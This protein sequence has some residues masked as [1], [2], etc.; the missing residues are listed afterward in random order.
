M[1]GKWGR[2]VLAGAGLLVLV[3]VLLAL[4]GG[5][6]DVEAG[7]VVRGDLSV[8]VDEEGR[9]RLR[10]RYVVTSPV[11]GRVARIA[12]REGDS[13]AAGSLLTRV[14]PPPLDERARQEARARIAA[15]EAR[16]REAEARLAQARSARDQAVEAWRRREAI[17]GMGGLSEEERQ[18]FR[19]EAALSEEAVT[20]AE[21]VERAVRAELAAARA[22]LAG[23][24]SGA[25]VDVR[26][27]AEGRVLRI[28]ERSERIVTAGEVLLELGTEEVL[29]V[30]VDVLSADAVRIRAG[31]P[32]W[33][34]GWGADSALH[35]RVARV[36]PSAFTRIS[37]LGVEEQRVNVILDLPHAPPALGDGYRVEARIETWSGENRLLA[38]SAAIFRRGEQWHAFAVRSGRAVLVPLR[39]GARGTLAVEVLDGLEEGD[40]VVLYPS[41]RVSDGVRVRTT[42]R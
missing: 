20:A 13:V 8:T 41:D 42:M 30:V 6:V 9:V 38:P 35:A 32:A 36:E 23:E 3:L 25:T 1:R 40:V 31:A 17:A 26:A 34:V 12:L 4:R 37:A 16:L 18:R 22:A 7:R 27:P 24:A 33:L 28:P 15:A 29:E 5:A 10:D 14:A 21:A 11:T 19:T 2:W 39:V